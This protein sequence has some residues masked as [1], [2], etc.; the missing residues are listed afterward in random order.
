MVIIAHGSLM[1]SAEALRDLR[2]RQ[3]H[4]VAIVDVEDLYDE[5]NFGAK[6]P[7]AIRAFL[8]RAQSTWSVPPRFVVLLGDAT[9]DPRDHRGKGDF[10][11]VP[12]KL[13]ETS[14]L[15][16]ASDDWFAAFHATGVPEIAIGRIPARTPDQADA[17]IAKIVAHDT[18]DR[19]EQNQIV[20][21]TDQS[22]TDN[23]FAAASRA[24]V[25]ALPPWT[26]LQM[27][28]ADDPE[29]KSS[30]VAALDAGPMVVNY[31]GHGY[32]GGWRAGAFDS[33]VAQTLT[34]LDRPSLFLNMT[35]LNG[36]FQDVDAPALAEV[37]LS[38]PRGGAL[39]VWA[40]SGVTEALPQSVLNQRFLEASLNEGLT[41]GES[42]MQ[43]KAATDDP[44]VRATW[45]LFGDP[46]T[47]LRPAKLASVRAI[48]AHTLGC[49]LRGSERRDADGLAASSVLLVSAAISRLARKRRARARRS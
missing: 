14:L 19:P 20:V 24:A 21:F 3:G 48:T 31:L 41:I 15:E 25:A 44:D 45:I 36:F 6:S 11:L 5:F 32:Q 30:L 39:A 46:S 2:R 9:L 47:S 27:L 34:N 12:T 23:D 29:I 13:V 40:S 22:S 33:S 38:T 1:K 35:C 43:A 10:D 18:V 28:S 37:L 16:T 17:I 26:P 8:A 49:S 7:Y 4:S 42:A